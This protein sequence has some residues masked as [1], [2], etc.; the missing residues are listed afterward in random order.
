M[1]TRLYA[2]VDNVRLVSSTKSIAASTSVAASMVSARVKEGAKL[3][4]K[5]AGLMR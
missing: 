1:V 5:K 3:V 4:L 2:D